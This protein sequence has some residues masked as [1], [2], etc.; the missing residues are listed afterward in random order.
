MTVRLVAPDGVG[1]AWLLPGRDVV[2]MTESDARG[3]LG[4]HRDGALAGGNPSGTRSGRGCPSEGPRGHPDDGAPNRRRRW[5]A[6]SADGR[7][8]RARF[9]ARAGGDEGQNRTRT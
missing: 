5:M 9:G 8:G 4:S 1:A 2:E 7:D 6:M 3:R